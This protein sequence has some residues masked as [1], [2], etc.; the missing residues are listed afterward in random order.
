MLFQTKVVMTMTGFVLLIAI[1][2]VMARNEWVLKMF[3][4]WCLAFSLGYLTWSLISYL[5]ACLFNYF[6]DI[7]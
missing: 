3:C 2:T 7:N 1:A 5:F 4:K 6:Y